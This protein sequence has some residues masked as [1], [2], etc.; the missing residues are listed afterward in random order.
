MF[1]LI[2]P[3]LIPPLFGAADTEVFR[4]Y[5]LTWELRSN[6]LNSVALAQ[7]IENGADDRYSRSGPKVLWNGILRQSV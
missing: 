6:I 4:R 2:G 3:C 7:K 1:F 5:L